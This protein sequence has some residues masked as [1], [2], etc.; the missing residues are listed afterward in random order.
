MKRLHHNKE[1]ALFVLVVV[2]TL[3]LS[4]FA[5]DTSET[6]SSSRITAAIHL[7]LGSNS[8]EIIANSTYENLT[9]EDNA[10]YDFIYEEPENI[11]EPEIIENI[12]EPDIPTDNVTI[13][14]DLTIPENASIPDNFTVPDNLTSPENVSVPDNI[15]LPDAFTIPENATHDFVYNETETIDN[16]TIP[17]NF[18]L[19]VN[20]TI[21]DNLTMPEPLDNI[22]VPEIISE[23]AS[24]KKMKEKSDKKSMKELGSILDSVVDYY[25]EDVSMFLKK[26][27]LQTEKE[28][29]HLEGK[30]IVCSGVMNVESYSDELDENETKI[31][32]DKGIPIYKGYNETEYFRPELGTRFEVDWNSIKKIHIGFKSDSFYIQD[33]YYGTCDEGDNCS[34]DVGVEIK[35]TDSTIRLPQE[36]YLKARWDFVNDASDSVTSNFILN[37]DFSSGVDGLG[38]WTPI[39]DGGD[40]SINASDGVLNM[41]EGPTTSKYMKTY[42][43]ITTTV[44]ET[45]FVN[46]TAVDASRWNYKYLEVGTNAPGAGSYAGNIISRQQLAQGENLATFTSTGTTIYITLANYDVANGWVLFDNVSVSGQSNGKVHG[47]DHTYERYDFDDAEYID[48]GNDASLKLNQGGSIGGWVNIYHLGSSWDNTIIMKGDGAS[49][50]NIHYGFFEADGTDRIYL[51]MSNSTGSLTTSGPKTA[52]LVE[53]KWYHIIG[54]WNSSTKCIYLDGIQQ[55]CVETSIMPPD[56]MT[57]D[58]VYIGVTA[59]THYFFNGSIENIYIWNTSLTPQEIELLYNE[60][61]FNTSGNTQTYSGTFTGGLVKK[62]N[63]FLE[64]KNISWTSTEPTDTI[65]EL[66]YRSGNFTRVDET[67]SDLVSYWKLNRSDGTNQFGTSIPDDNQ[68]L[69][70]KFNSESDFTD[71]SGHGNTGTNYGSAYTNLGYIGGARSFDAVNDYVDFGDLDITGDELSIGAW[72]NYAGPPDN[73]YAGILSKY[74]S[75]TIDTGVTGNLEVR[76]Y[77]SAGDTTLSCGKDL[78]N[79]RDEW[80]HVFLTYGNNV[81]TCYWD[82]LPQ[83]SSALA[84]GSLDQNANKLYAGYYYSGGYRFNGLIDNIRLYNTSLNATQVKELYSKEAG[85]YD[86]KGSN[87][88]KAENNVDRDSGLFDNDGALEFDGNSAGVNV[89][90]SNSL[91]ITNNLSIVSWVYVKGKTGFNAILSRFGSLGYW[92]GLSGNNAKPVLYVNVTSRYELA[93][94]E[95]SL[96]QWVQLAAVYNASD[97]NVNLYVDGSKVAS[98]T[99][100]VIPPGINSNTFTTS[101]GGDVERANYYFNGSIDSVAIYNRTLSSN[102]ISDLYFTWSGWNEYDDTS[103][104]QLKNETANTLQYEARLNTTNNSLTPVL[105]TV[106]VAFTFDINTSTFSTDMSVGTITNYYGANEIVYVTDPPGESNASKY[107]VPD[108]KMTEIGPFS[109]GLEVTSDEKIYSGVMQSEFRFFIENKGDKDETVDVNFLFQDKGSIGKVSEV[110]YENVELEKPVYGKKEFYCNDGWNFINKTINACDPGEENN[111]QFIEVKNTDKVIKDVAELIDENNTLIINDNSTINNTFKENIVNN[112]C[113]MTFE[114]WECNSDLNSTNEGNCDNVTENKK[115]CTIDKFVIGTESVIKQKE[116]FSE[117]SV[118]DGN[119][120]ES[121]ILESKIDEE[122][123]NLQFAILSDKD[124][125]NKTFALNNKKNTFSAKKKINS[126]SLKKGEFKEFKAM[127]IFPESSSGEFMIEAKSESNS[128]ALLDPWWQSNWTYKLPV[129]I[130]ATK[131]NRTDYLIQLG[132]NFTI[133]FADANT[134]GTMCDNC[135]RIVEYNKTNGALLAEL[136]SKFIH[137]AI[138]YDAATNAYGRIDWVLN[139]TT[140]KDTIRNY[141]IF[142][143]KTEN[144]A[145]SA[146]VAFDDS[147]IFFYPETDLDQDGLREIVAG[148]QNGFAI[149]INGEDPAH[150]V[151]W[152]SPDLGSWVS[153][154]IGDT[155]GNGIPDFV[156]A[157]IASTDDIPVYEYNKT[158]DD[159]EEIDNFITGTTHYGVSVC[160][161]DRDGYDEIILP[162][163]SYD[164]VKI[165]G[166]D[167]AAYVLEATLTITDPTYWKA[168]TDP[169]IQEKQVD[170]QFH[171]GCGDVDNDGEFQIIT[172]HYLDEGI[173]IWN[174]NGVEYEHE[175]LIWETVGVHQGVTLADPDDDGKYEVLIADADQFKFY[176]YDHTGYRESSLGPDTGSYIGYP[177]VLDW[178]AD[179][180]MET[181]YGD[182]EGNIHVYNLTSTGAYTLE[183]GAG[184]DVGAYNYATRFGDIDGDGT[185]EL[186]TGN[187]GGA[188]FAFNS[189]TTTREWT[190]AYGL[191]YLGSYYGDS[192]LISGEKDPG[193]LGVGAPKIT[194]GEVMTAPPQSRIDNTGTKNNISAFVTMK[195]QNF[196]G[197]KWHNASIVVNLSDQNISVG[198][199]IKLDALWLNKGGWN[200]A[201][202]PDGI[203]RVWVEVTNA[204]GS[205]MRNTDDLT[206][207]NTSYE[208]EIDSTP[209]VISDYLP[210]NNTDVVDPSITEENTYE[211]TVTIT[212]DEPAVCKFSEQVG[213]AWD[214]MYWIS[215]DYQTTHFHRVQLIN[216]NN[217]DYYFICQDSVGNPS[218]VFHLN[219]STLWTDRPTAGPATF[220]PVL[221]N[222][223]ETLTL[224]GNCYDLDT[225]YGMSD[226]RF[227]GTQEGVSHNPPDWA[228]CVGTSCACSCTVDADG[229]GSAGCPDKSLQGDWMYQVECRDNQNEVDSKDFDVFGVKAN[230]TWHAESQSEIPVIEEGTPRLLNGIYWI[231][232]DGPGGNASFQIYCDMSEEGGGWMLLDNFVSSLGGDSDPYGAAIGYSNIKSLANLT[233]AGYTTYINGIEN[234]S[235]TRVKGYLQL[236]YGGAPV[237]Y[238]QKTLPS[239]ANEV[240]V[241]WGNWYSGTARLKIGGSTVQTLSGNYGAATYRGDYALNDLIRLEESGIFWAGEVWVKESVSNW[242]QE[243]DGSSSAKA[244]RSCLAI[245]DRYDALYEN[246]SNALTYDKTVTVDNLLGSESRTTGWYHDAGKS[247]YSNITEWSICKGN[248]CSGVYV[249][250]DDF[251]I[252]TDYYARVYYMKSFGDK[253]FQDNTYESDMG[254]Y[255]WGCGI[256]DFV[257]DDNSFDFVSG[258]QGNMYLFEHTAEGTFTRTLIGTITTPNYVMDIATQDFTGDNH[259]DFVVSGNNDDL[260]LFAGNGSGDFKKIVITAAGPD[261]VIYGKA[262]L[263]FDDDGDYDVVFGTNTNKIYILNN[264]DGAGTFTVLDTGL[265]ARNTYNYGV[266]AGDMDND[267]FDDI[268]VEYRGYGIVDYFKGKGDG[269]FQARATTNIDGPNN[270]MPMDV[271]DYNKDGYLDIVATDYSF[272]NVFY[273]AGHGDFNFDSSIDLGMMGANLMGICAPVIGT[274]NGEY[275]KESGANDDVE[276]DISSPQHNITNETLCYTWNYSLSASDCIPEQDTTNITIANV[277]AYEKCNVTVSNAAELSANVTLLDACSD[278]AYWNGSGEGDTSDSYSEIDCGNKSLIVAASGE[279]S[280]I[281][282]WNESG[283]INLTKSSWGRN[284]TCSQFVAGRQYHTANVSLINDEPINFTDVFWEVSIPGTNTSNVTNGTIN[285]SISG[286]NISANVWEPCNVAPGVTLVYPVNNTVLNGRNIDFRCNAQSPSVDNVT[287]LTLYIW[288]STKD[289]IYSNKQS[290]NAISVSQNWTY[291]LPSDGT[292]E[293]N[294]NASD[295]FASYNFSI[296]NNTFT[297]T[298]PEAN[299]YGNVTTDVDTEL[300]P[301]DSLIQLPRMNNLV[302]RWDF[303]TNADDSS[304]QDHNGTVS[305]ATHTFERYDFD[306]SDEY[307]D[308]GSITL[309]TNNV[310]MNV[311][312]KR[313]D[314]ECQTFANVNVN[315]F[316]I[317]FCWGALYGYYGQVQ[318]GGYVPSLNDW[319]MHTMTFN[320]TNVS[321][322]SDGVKRSEWSDTPYNVGGQSYIGWL[323]PTYGQDLNGS[324]DSVQIWNTSLTAEEITELYRA[325]RFNTEGNTVDYIGRYTNAIDS[326]NDNSVWTNLTWSETEPVGTTIDLR[327]RLGNYTPVDVTDSDLVGYWKL[328]RSDGTTGNSTIDDN[329]VLHLKF[330][331]KTDFYDYSGK[332]YSG[333]NDGSAYTNVGYIGGARSFDGTTNVVYNSAFTAISANSE[334]TIT[335]WVKDFYLGGGGQAVVVG[336]SDA[337]AR[338]GLSTANNLRMYNSN[339]CLVSTD[340]TNYHDGWHFIAT[341]VS[342]DVLSDACCI[343]VDGNAWTCDTDVGNIG[344]SSAYYVGDYSIGHSYGISG[345]IDNVR[346]YNNTYLTQ[347]QL[348]EIYSKEA[349]TYDETGNNL[350]TAYNNVDRSAG[351]FSNDLALE[352][353]GVDDWINTTS[354]SSLNIQ[355][356][357]AISVWLKTLDA[358]IAHKNIVSRE[359]NTGGYQFYKFTSGITS[360]RIMFGDWNGYVYTGTAGIQDGEWHHVV[361]INNGSTDCNDLQIYIDGTKRGTASA[362]VCNG[363]ADTTKAVTIGARIA[364]S[365]IFQPFNGS[366]DSVAIYNRTLSSNEI[367]DLYINWSGWSTYS[368]SGPVDLGN[369]T[370]R[371]L[372]YQALLNTSNDSVTPVFGSFESTSSIPPVVTLLY[373]VNDTILN[374][375]NVDFRCTASTTAYNIRNITLFIWKSGG[376][377]VYSNTQTIN[378]L[379]VSQNWTYTLPSNGTYYYICEAEKDD[380]YSSFASGNF[381]FNVTFNSAG[382][383]VTTDVD[384]ELKPFDSLETLPR[385]NNLVGRWDFEEDATDTSIYGNNGTVHGSTHTFERY[386]FDGVN[387]NI[388]ITDNL[389]TSNINMSWGLWFKTSA[390]LPA[391]SEL[392]NQW[393]NAGV[394]NRAWSL[395]MGTTERLRCYV[396]NGSSSPGSLWSAVLNDGFW[397]QAICVYNGTNINLYIDGSVVGAGATPGGMQDSTNYDITIGSTAGNT[398]WFNGSLENAYLWNTSLSAEEIRELYR[399]TRFNTEGDTVKFFGRHTNAISTRSNATIWKNFSW[400]ETE[401]AG[402]NIKVRYRMGNFTPVDTSDANLIGYWKLN[403]SDGT[404]QFGTSNPDSYQVLH[405]KFNS[406][407]DFADYSGRENNGTNEGS[408]YTNLGYI[409]GARVFDGSNDRIG[410]TTGP[411]LNFSSASEPFT[412]SGWIK[413][414]DVA[415]AGSRQTLI[416]NIETA[417]GW[418]G[419]RVGI[420]FDAAKFTIANDASMTDAISISV[421]GRNNEW[422]HLVGR[423]NGTGI[424]IFVNGE[425]N[426]KNPWFVDITPGNTTTFIGYCPDSGLP[427]ESVIDNVR[428]YNTSLTNSQIQ[429]LYSKEAGT[430]DEVNNNHGTAINNVDRTAGIFNNDLALEFDGVDDFANFSTV[431]DLTLNNNYSIAVWTKIRGNGEPWGTYNNIFSHVLGANDKVS[432]QYVGFPVFAISDLRVGHWDGASSHPKSATDFNGILR[433]TWYLIVMNHYDDLKNEFF[434]NSVNQTSA[435]SPSTSATTGFVLGANSDQAQNFFNGTIDSVAIYNRTLTPIEIEALYTNWSGWST[436]QAAS[437][438]DLNNQTGRAIQYQALLNT[439]NGSN[440]PV[441]GS[442]EY[443]STYVPPSLTLIYPLNDTVLPGRNVDFRC[444]AVSNNGNIVNMTLYI[445][446]ASDDSLVHSNTQITAAISVSQ[447]W[448]YILPSAGSFEYNCEAIY[449]TG[450]LNFASNNN[451]FNVTF[452]NGI[453]NVTTDVDTE[454]KPVDSLITLP[455]LN[456]LVGRWDFVTNADDTSGQDHNGTVHSATHEFERYVFNVTD[457]DIITLNSGTGYLENYTM[458]LWLRRDQIGSVFRM[459]GQGDSTAQYYAFHGSQTN[460]ILLSYRNSNNLQRTCYSDVTVDDYDWHHVVLT[461]ESAG[462]ITFYIDNIED[463][464]TGSCNQPAVS[465]GFNPAVSTLNYIGGYM[466]AVNY[467]FNGSIDSFYI[468]NTTLS[469]EEITE[470]YRAT[471]FNTEGDTVKF[472]GKYT[473]AIS[474]GSDATV[475]KNFSWLETEPAGT[476]IDLRY[477]LGNYTSVNTTATDLIGYWK[478]NRSDATNIFNAANPDYNQVLDMKFNSATDFKDYALNTNNGTNSGSAYT[479]LGYIGGARSFDGSNDYVNCGDIDEAEGGSEITISSWIKTTDASSNE[480]WL[481]KDDGGG[482]RSWLF[483][484]HGVAKLKFYV[485]DSGGGAHFTVSDNNIVAREWTHVVGIYNGSI[486]K[487]YV[488]G[489]EQTNTASWAD[490]IRVSNDNVYIGSNSAGNVPWNGLIDNVRIYN[491]SLNSSQVKELYS[492]EAGTYDE[493]GNNLGTAEN[494]VDRD[495]G[496]FEDDL[497]LEFDGEE[498]FINITSGS[499]ALKL[500]NSDATFISWIYPINIAATF[501]MIIG[502]NFYDGWQFGLGYSNKVILFTD[503]TGVGDVAVSTDTVSLNTWNQVV[504]VWDDATKTAQFYINGIAAG[505]EANANDI[506]DSSNTFYI[507]VD[508]RVG[509]LYFFNGTIDSIAV[510][511][512]SLTPNEIS[513]LYINWSG[514]S[515]Y[516]AASPI[517]LNNQTGRALQYQA[518]LNTT[519]GSNT[520]VFSSAEATTSYPPTIT[521]I[522]PINDTILPGRNVDFRCNAVTDV[523]HIKNITLYIWSGGTLVYN[524]TQ[525]SSGYSVSQNWTYILP[526]NATYEYNCRAYKIDYLTAEAENNNTFTVTFPDGINNVTTDVD[527]ELKPVDSLITLPAV[528]N[529]VGRW[530][531][532]ENA[533]DSSGKDNNGTVHG[534][535]HTFE[536]Y[537]FDGT[538]DYIDT[539]SRILDW[540]QTD[541]TVSAWTKGDTLANGAAIMAYGHTNDQPY[542]SWNI[543]YITATSEIKVQTFNGS[544]ANYLTTGFDASNS[545]WFLITV[546]Y[547]FSNNNISVYINNEHRDSDQA[548]LKLRTDGQ[549]DSIIIGAGR[550]GTSMHWNGSIDSVQIWNTSLSAEEITELYRATRFNTEGDTVKFLGRYTNAI[551]TGSNATIWKNLSWLETEPAGTD[552]NLRYRLGNYTSIDTSD[553]G[554]VTYWKFNRSDATNAF[555]NA[556][557]DNNLIVHYK[558]KNQTDYFD[559]SGTG[560]IISSF[561]G[562]AYTNLGYMGGA[563]VLDG[564]NDYLDTVDTTSLNY[565]KAFGTI[566]M[567][568]KPDRLDVTNQI[569]SCFEQGGGWKSI[570]G[571]QNDGDLYFYPSNDA[572]NYNLITTPL[573]VN[574]W[575]HVLVT[576]D[577]N[578]R[579][580]Y[581]Y[582]NGINQTLTIENIPTNWLTNLSNIDNLRI[583][584]GSG[585][586]YLKGTVDNYRLYNT[587][588]NSTQILELYSKEAGTYDEKG[589][590]LGIVMNDVDRTAGIFNDDGALEF[591]GHQDYINFSNDP[592]M[593]FSENITVSAWFK[594]NEYAM[595]IVSKGIWK[596]YGWDMYVSTNGYGRFATFDVPLELSASTINPLPKGEWIHLVG[597][598]DTTDNRIYLNGVKQ[599]DSPFGISFPAADDIDLIVGLNSSSN[600]SN[601]YD[602]NG[603]IDSIAIYNRTLTEKEIQALYINW[604]GWSTYQGSSPINLNNQT[605]RALQYQALLN[606]T[607]N[608]VTPVLGTVSEDYFKNPL[609]YLDS[610]ANNTQ[611]T[612][613]TINLFCNATAFDSDRLKNITLYIWNASNVL[614]YSNTNDLNG[615]TNQSNWTYTFANRGIF[616][617]NCEAKTIADFSDLADDNFTLT[618]LKWVEINLTAPINGSVLP[619]GNELIPYED[620]LDAVNNDVNLIANV[621]DNETLKGVN[622]VN[623][624]FYLDAS[625]IGYDL[626]NSS[627][628]C[629]LTYDKHTQTF[630]FRNIS[631]NYSSLPSNYTT[632]DNNDYSML[633]LEN[634]TMIIDIYNYRNI[635]G[636]LYYGDD[637]AGVNV[638]IRKDGALNNITNMT[639]ILTNQLDVEFNRLHLDNFT[640]FG[641]GLYY[642]EIVVSIPNWLRWKGYA[643]SNFTNYGILN[644]TSSL[645]TDVEVDPPVP[646]VNSTT[647]NASGKVFEN[648]TITYYRHGPLFIHSLYEKTIN[649]TDQYITRTGIINDSTYQIKFYIPDNNS[650]IID[651]LNNN[652]NYL[653]IKTQ[654]AFHIGT[655]PADIR[656]LSKIIACN[657]STFEK[658]S[659]YIQKNNFEPDRICECQNWNFSSANC[660]GLWQCNATSDYEY[661][662]N[663]T[664]FAFNVTHF[665]GFAGGLAFDAN[666][667]IWDSTDPEAGSQKIVPNQQAMFYANYTNSSD[668]LIINGSDIF[669]N[670][671]FDVGGWTPLANMTFNTTSMLYEYNR[672][673]PAVAIYDWNVTC[674]GAVLNYDILEA[675]DTINISTDLAAPYINFTSPTMPNGTYNQDWISV[676]V[677]AVDFNLDTI[678]INLFNSSNT[679]INFTNSLTSPLYFNFT[680]LPDGLYYF[681]ATANDTFG[682]T[683]STETRNITLDTTAPIIQL[684]SPPNGAFRFSPVHFTYSVTDLSS[685]NCSLII[686]DVIVATSTNLSS[687]IQS[688]N[689]NLDAS[690]HKWNVS[691]ID[692]FGLSNASDVWNLTISVPAPARG[693][694]GGGG[695]RASYSINIE[696]LCINEKSKTSII[697]QSSGQLIISHFDKGKWEYITTLDAKSG[698]AYFTPQQIGTYRFDFKIFN[699]IVASKTAVAEICARTEFPSASPLMDLLK[700]EILKEI[701]EGDIAGEVPKEDEKVKEKTEVDEF[702]EK[703]KLVPD[704]PL[705]KSKQFRIK[706][707]I[708]SLLILSIL[709]GFLFKTVKMLKRKYR[710]K[711]LESERKKLKKKFN[712]D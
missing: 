246:S 337:V 204:S 543:Y 298:F 269:T 339:A 630:G 282:R 681:N 354:D 705:F 445:W 328:N 648:T 597:V 201:S 329:Q 408:A 571:L 616:E 8:S 374:G 461:A 459:F 500:V 525:A 255:S 523:A 574:E 499:N 277:T 424:S 654:S 467:M 602:F 709:A 600:R 129:A 28:L 415:P 123:N 256:A 316:R 3:F 568:V 662:S 334:F 598:V 389:N 14:D 178:D 117:I 257:E 186:I 160:D 465:D 446:N 99:T 548:K 570:L 507:G 384:T 690:E 621:Y 385:L 313:T 318:G 227:A 578:K 342:S 712:V 558:F 514:W 693:G 253:S 674:N 614:I 175:Q 651:R 323:N 321:V 607:N 331:N 291:I 370:S 479:N 366:I 551:S 472:F 349:G 47:A 448:T 697:P 484:H 38:S 622:N 20:L 529:L 490:T 46:L 111:T 283:A 69:H 350:G 640:Q 151:N 193:A 308:V 546:T 455:A 675:N 43:A 435:S 74:S 115:T 428:V 671:E 454:L 560:N 165:W 273:Y 149:V 26:C 708:S 647:L 413:T 401:P 164:N 44:G 281:F 494:N 143:D 502:N 192:L 629:N 70:M 15:T 402:T 576:W 473:N 569:L 326:G 53:N 250:K 214:D 646:T 372:Q 153:L 94:A 127:L 219:F 381:T 595:M 369:V 644:A 7:E 458:S 18:T 702:Y 421:A 517:D 228:N 110:I 188:L 556:N 377:L 77:A 341:K 677:T 190:K 297:V 176:S 666:L 279:N 450:E 411:D 27:I 380:L 340:Y 417:A 619:R 322:Y 532:V 102:E 711:K 259:Y 673:F 526:S 105:N 351:I 521:L 601:R 221:F 271:W 200:T 78:D 22:T 612:N 682:N 592:S 330:N 39:V 397:H 557:S 126:I 573:T 5:F 245:K 161:V 305:G 447:N 304:G 218:S 564:S 670:I 68:M 12:T 208:F 464:P 407:T 439:T 456:N 57:G 480:D 650:L 319:H 552:I 572:N 391:N 172:G 365:T 588:L 438:I 689:Y 360:D 61:R 485:W 488:N 382:N 475:W 236:F 215:I 528:N 393:L 627:G 538:A 506:K 209:P 311:W 555:D 419:W 452:P 40:G 628:I 121:L 142:F 348:E 706:V 65:I 217:Y 544:V 293:F 17:D 177:D 361:G 634:W 684:I 403:R 119:N 388:I 695:S 50:N 358:S 171:V 235:Y 96:N 593:N 76:L 59:G 195:V 97:P 56:D 240:Y 474:T 367:S 451:T 212:T 493:T 302:G 414:P 626:T 67:D 383:N 10:S 542:E 79:F 406:A 169:V 549:F 362:G 317:I 613:K 24:I 73:N 325:T 545:D 180:N 594:T 604:S 131:Y 163:Y 410:I 395:R 692:D 530:D 515:T 635:G 504:A 306:G 16:L 132:L 197:G 590:N 93:D 91:D 639:I 114:T 158:T 387:D 567:W 497:A 433:D 540:N 34:I 483:W 122:I 207:M 653:R 71:Y 478:L 463:F 524:N 589:N 150:N 133:L 303:V 345:M 185:V 181:V 206:L 194:L 268:L 486:Q 658:A 292:Y 443:V 599:T 471:R 324:I 667:S 462:N 54:T 154:A 155:N 109:E 108:F 355:E 87:H 170:D 284:G 166:W 656:N 36:N 586:A 31:F 224:S 368:T 703:P 146:P 254:Y 618:I 430:Y 286:V 468:W 625:Y 636:A 582:I 559:F 687:G 579:N 505:S 585:L 437:P 1:F 21:P 299:F 516:Q 198:N 436:Y 213:D 649:L 420:N 327:Y 669:C 265:T 45:Y 704:A 233:Y 565:T 404:N 62:T 416:S 707:F 89:T 509:S 676:N 222:N 520:P 481:A 289:L 431:S 101:I 344:A 6:S 652:K 285:V 460:R 561:T 220:T 701:E 267:G 400:Q 140:V 688:F 683:N 519:N 444:N 139:G 80:H 120:Q 174:Y 363:F 196:T 51:L 694:G 107:I 128:Y 264:T 75:Y 85:T 631:V 211:Y 37:G 399:A 55:E 262:A 553:S 550:G 409:G 584:F 518:L 90:E 566:S 394:G 312:A 343:S 247:L 610:P 314:N 19:P 205:V 136:P 441:F 386:E 239:Y 603:T 152:T 501:N 130:N 470:L 241:K 643:E 679:L 491:T 642:A 487:M 11:T 58:T 624:S 179:G 242:T 580:A 300:K 426:S 633:N 373:P 243:D 698:Y 295:N 125:E 405:M 449:Q 611:T 287:S 554:L 710:S 145:K 434:L 274:S 84:K 691:C 353:D 210:L 199:Y 440:T 156:A 187:S 157:P 423:F 280:S 104:I 672:T 356:N 596:K 191:G 81:T 364:G 278:G 615:I 290:V 489:V 167:G 453:D 4:Y 82:A 396:D 260:W 623:C 663:T 173:N 266:A 531:F 469:R 252:T 72:I 138:D 562:S 275:H 522:Y 686:D 98:T 248:N 457:N 320:G 637:I 32:A 23:K 577:Y 103:P 238:I 699:N 184:I 392:F 315:N 492:K 49:W 655:N 162:G 35:P 52:A 678:L 106:D 234:P 442:V 276:W 591:D 495:S 60:T 581:F 41:S 141:Y 216:E 230:V 508:G 347:A 100:G 685:V 335:A 539:N 134:T 48:A 137:R 375:R 183:Y 251:V 9:K 466:S 535:T 352:F 661:K 638:T 527:T 168:T 513:D 13:P 116:V 223:T 668:G 29:C 336:M 477:R 226:C 118:N 496:I 42:Q 371:A 144:G 258:A 412:V 510:Y 418:G 249:P 147:Q 148:S 657:I 83:S 33:F 2:L 390:Q 296:T 432:I 608:S 498:D 632:A 606:T 346:I 272:T 88:G 112:A 338:F 378:A 307:I 332:G 512:R 587:S 64:W 536:R 189:S 503:G 575:T 541:W 30:E 25:C 547:D 422:L 92:F 225:V 425:I 700:S 310:T 232:P 563:R 620:D 664:H 357:L 583:G 86:I 182:Y 270:Y 482:A 511:N 63:R 665:S 609:V 229:V 533:D 534:A 660:E 66:R 476:K 605:G 376:S 645:H 427:S 231:D 263:D 135:Y 261:T 202:N 333:T 680:N 237:G 659:I 696:P 301:V 429:E 294:C 398:G 113:F 159:Y 359:D 641:D 288:N 203:Y 617:W 95:I 379:S 537:D 124:K 244:A 309:G